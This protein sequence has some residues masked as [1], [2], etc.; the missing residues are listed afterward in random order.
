MFEAYNVIVLDVIPLDV[1]QWAARRL[2]TD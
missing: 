1:V 2:G